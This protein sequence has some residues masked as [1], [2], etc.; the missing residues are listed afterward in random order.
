MSDRII[1]AAEA[2]ELV[3]DGDTV[4]TS[5]F[6]GIGVPDALLDAIGDRFAAD[7]HPRDLT[8]LFAAGQGDGKERGLNRLAESGKG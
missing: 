3:H 2:A 7:A 5:G 6:V 8:V 1:T 4:T